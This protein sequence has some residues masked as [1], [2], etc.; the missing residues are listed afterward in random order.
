[1]MVSQRPGA[2]REPR[3]T[4]GPLASRCAYGARVAAN[5]RRRGSISDFGVGVA[6]GY[7]TVGAIGFEGRFD[8][9]A[10]GTVTNLAARLCSEAKPGQILAARRL[11]A[12]VED[13]VEAEAVGELSLKGF[14]RPIAAYN[15]LALRASG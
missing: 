9:G 11:L 2:G 15:V 3:G 5:W 10:I 12:T 13:L 14:Q 6:Q 7:A 4:G 8:Y 1:M